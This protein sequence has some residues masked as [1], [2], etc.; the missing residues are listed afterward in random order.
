M[1]T[2]RALRVTEGMPGSFKKWCVQMMALRTRAPV[3]IS[4]AGAGKARAKICDVLGNKRL[5]FCQLMSVKQL[6]PVFEAVM[7]GMTLRKALGAW[8][9]L[10]AAVVFG[11]C[12]SRV[13]L[14]YLVRTRNRLRTPTELE[15]FRMGL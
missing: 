6:H 7:D 1:H 11:L 12:R 9:A 15:Q 10:R 5:G 4:K 8:G 14:H 2:F 13:V 3:K